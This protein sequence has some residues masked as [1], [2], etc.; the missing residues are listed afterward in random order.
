M[1][2]DC[3]W[4]AN[5]VSFLEEKLVFLPKEGIQEEGFNKL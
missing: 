5:D 4:F 2:N 1:E 3:F